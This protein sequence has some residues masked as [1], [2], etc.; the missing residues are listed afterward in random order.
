MKQKRR[1]SKILP[2]WLQLNW[3]ALQVG[4]NELDKLLLDLQ[5]SQL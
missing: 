5:V 4:A 3:L 2:Y 1:G